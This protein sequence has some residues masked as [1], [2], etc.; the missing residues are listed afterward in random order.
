LGYVSPYT[1]T[2]VFARRPDKRWAAL[3]GRIPDTRRARFSTTEGLRTNAWTDAQLRSLDGCLTHGALA[4]QLRQ[5]RLRT[6]GQIPAAIAMMNPAHRARSLPPAA[7]IAPLGRMTRERHSTATIE[8]VT[9]TFPSYFQ[10]EHSC[11]RS[12]GAP[13]RSLSFHH[14]QNCLVSLC[15]T[16]Q[17]GTWGLLKK[18]LRGIWTPHSR[19]YRCCNVRISSGP[20]RKCK[21]FRGSGG[22]TLHFIEVKPAKIATQSSFQVFSASPTWSPGWTS[23][24]ALQDPL[25]RDAIASRSRKAAY[26]LRDRCWSALA[27]GDA[28]RRARSPLCYGRAA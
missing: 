3:A 24:C 8:P 10:S 15:G 9:Y 26:E 18:C 5:G 1:R 28:L 20:H 4:S 21:D 14:P 7:R 19:S 17:T 12:V 16:R 25:P 6:P 27:G 2:G 23:V 22:K 11:D 13:Q